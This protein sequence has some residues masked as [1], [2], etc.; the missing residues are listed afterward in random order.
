MTTLTARTP[1]VLQADAAL[2]ARRPS[3]TAVASGSAMTILVRQARAELLKLVRAPDFVAPVVILPVVLFALFG[4]PAIGAFTDDGVALGPLLAASFTA[5]GVLGI[6]LF[7][8]G[9]AVASER[10]Q[11]WLRL[12]RATP[13]PGWAFVAAKLIAGLVLVL[14][15]LT[16]MVPSA[17]V[18]G[19]KLDPTSWARLGATVAIGGLALAP[20][21]F[22]VG[23][24]VR[25]NAAG[26]V[27]LLMYLPLSYASGMWTPIRELPEVVQSIAHVLPTYHL[28]QLGHA[29]V[30]VPVGDVS[31]HILFLLAT[32]AVGAGLSAAA[33]RRV[34]ARQFA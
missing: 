5:Y 23:L 13:L 18:L 19:V 9:E 29:A 24:L 32:F 16:V 30:G 22:I 14:L 31:G 10:G 7:T 17:T 6:V 1:A 2:P 4:S 11:G 27:A 28:N 8:F 12:I 33:Y 34:A 15:F 3:P 20:I 21:G 26:A 25:S